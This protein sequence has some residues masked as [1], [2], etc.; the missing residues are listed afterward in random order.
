EERRLFY[1]AITRAEKRLFL[2]HSNI[3][4]KW[5]QYIDSEASRFLSELD[6]RYITKKN[7]LK[8]QKI[9]R[10]PHKI[11]AKTKTTTNKNF[12]PQGFK[13]TSKFS[14][15]SIKKSNLIKLKN[16]QIVKHEK[17][18]TGKVINLEG[19]GSSKKATV[20]FN[21]IGNKQLLLKFAKLEILK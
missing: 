17:F 14:N 19:E 15:T 3:R 21:G 4:F 10:N 18:G 8:D 6:Q 2:S 1:V 20:F 16:G 7:F 5:G 11:F 12:S 13:K 9:S